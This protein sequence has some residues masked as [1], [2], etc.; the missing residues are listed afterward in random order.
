MMEAAVRPMF[1]VVDAPGFDRLLRIMQ[2]DKPALVQTFI[3]Q[4]AVKAFRVRILYRFSWLDEVECDVMRVG[5]LIQR[6]TAK[7][8]A[9]IAHNF[10]R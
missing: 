4:A 7:F 10:G 9:V 5:L 3:A 1:V 2:A 8:W 6:F